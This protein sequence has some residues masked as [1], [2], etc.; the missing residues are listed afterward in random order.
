MTD[1]T[2]GTRVRVTSGEFAGNDGVITDVFTYLEDSVN[3]DY[4]VVLDNIK[5]DDVDGSYMIEDY[6]L[7]AI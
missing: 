5:S 6:E 4:D 2:I 3:T 1:L 7:E